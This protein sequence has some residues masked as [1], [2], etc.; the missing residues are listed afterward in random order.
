MITQIDPYVWQKS[1]GGGLRIG[2][3]PPI[4]WGTNLEIRLYW[5]IDRELPKPCNTE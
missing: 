1:D 5:L 2:I 3:G 4:I